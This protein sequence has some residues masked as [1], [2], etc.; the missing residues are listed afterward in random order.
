MKILFNRLERHEPWGGGSSF[1]NAMCS[2]LREKDHEIVFSLENNV[3]L[4]FMIDPRP[5]DTGISINE[6]I[7]YKI[8]NPKTK[9]LYRI[10]ECDARKNTAGMDNLLIQSTN[11]VD[12]VI[13]ISEWL[14]EYFHKKGLNVD[15]ADVVYNGCDLNN[16][17]PMVSNTKKIKL[18]THHW[19][20]NWMK[21]FDLYK[22]IDEYMN[23]NSEF[24]FTYI[25][26]YSNL[27]NPVNTRIVAPLYGK[28]LGEE[29]RKHD[30][31][32]TASRNEPC[33]MHHI[34][35]A[36]SG[37]PVI[38]H[39]NTGGIVE[40]CVNHGEEY[41]TFENFLD[42]LDK[43]KT[44]LTVYKKKINRDHLDIKTC[45]ENFYQ[46]IETLLKIDEKQQT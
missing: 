29:L 15:D 28:A 7:R 35:G 13:F 41:E 36:A 27:Y 40:M 20:D 31:Y 23:N 43:I 39:K 38:Y 11:H 45:C 18:V 1:V 2:L 44:N 14:K 26:R 10:N 4:I 30:I 32:V 9:I 42:C 17:Y 25:G 8:V 16:F 33:G 21:G 6:I 19:S 12:K 3:D 46:H 5:G 37:L 22:D 34:E 24:E